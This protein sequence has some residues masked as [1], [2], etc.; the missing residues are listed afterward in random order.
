MNK[1]EFDSS[2]FVGK[3]VYIYTKVSPVIKNWITNIFT[4][5]EIAWE[6][7]QPP[8]GSTFFCLYVQVYLQHH[9]LILK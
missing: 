4:H 8:L 7:L 3:P 1:N 9:W 6:I 2:I 5:E